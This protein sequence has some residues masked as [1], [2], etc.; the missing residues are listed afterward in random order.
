MLSRIHAICTEQVDKNLEIEKLKH[1][2]AKNDYPKEVVEK[3][4]ERF[5]ASKERIERERREEQ[6]ATPVAENVVK[7]VEEVKPKKFIVL[8]FTQRK[9]EDFANRLKRLVN[10]NFPQIDFNVAFQTPRSIG[11]LF[12]FKDNIKRTEDKAGV[13]YRLQCRDCDAAY[14]GK[15]Q[16]ILS[17]RLSEHEKNK[18]SACYQH[19]VNLK[20]RIDY[21]NAQIIDTASSD[22][23]LRVKELLHILKT[24]PSLNK[25]LNAQ[26]DFDIKTL[27][28][29][30]YPQF[31][32]ENEKS[33]GVAT[34]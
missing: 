4:V 31:R 34:R 17:I 18:K 32:Q 2:L 23:K 10:D 16:R 7:T 1:L 3:E 21:E 15:T 8:P 14:I 26:S 27:I 6:A 28:V 20:H 5:L 12:P 25:Q 30:A 22:L 9:C 19:S 29:Q 11:S 33:S 24:E 13:V